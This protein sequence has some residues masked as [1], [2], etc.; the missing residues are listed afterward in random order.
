MLA[1]MGGL[2]MIAFAKPIVLAKGLATSA[3]I[4]VLAIALFNSVGRLVWGMVS[5][6]IGR[7]K[8]IIILLSGTAVFS[9]CVNAAEGYWIYVLIALI[10]FFY[11]G[12][13]S[14]FPSLTADLFGSKHMA[15]NYGFV[16]VGFGVGAII[17]SQI[18]GYY[19]NA[20]RIA[21]DISLMFPAFVIASCCAAGG[22]LVMFILNAIYKK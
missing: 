11:G 22:I 13:L 9:L 7:E 5:D 16:L 12:F 19:R 21:D 18:A 2:M 17:S 3:T 8:T 1:S 4:G 10:G 14:N 6:K 20:A 15:A